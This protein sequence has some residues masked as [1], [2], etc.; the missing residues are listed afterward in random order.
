M[1][2]SAALAVTGGAA[3]IYAVSK[4]VSKSLWIPLAY[5][6]AMEALQAVQYIIVD[7][8]GLPANEILTILGYIHIAF[9]PFFINMVAMHFIPVTVRQKI[10]KYVYLL[11]GLAAVSMLVQLYPFVW[12][13][14]CLPGSMLCGETLCTVSGAWHIAWDVPLNGMYNAL[15]TFFHISMPGYVLVGLILPFLYGSWKLNLYQIFFGLFAASLITSNPNETAAV[16]CL[17]SIGVVILVLFE[18][19]VGRYLH[20]QKWFLWRWLLNKEK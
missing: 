10:A 1:E 17:L 15:Y 7:L 12:A 6:T 19:P 11:C 9:Q 3:T 18:K 5:F 8:C 13:G 2:A 20:V 4:K 14:Q 16:W